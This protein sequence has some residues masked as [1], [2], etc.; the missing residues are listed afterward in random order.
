MIRRNP[1]LA[2]H[3]REQTLRPNSRTAHQIS[4]DLPA[5]IESRHAKTA[6]T[7]SAAC[8]M[9]CRDRQEMVGS[10]VSVFTTNDIA[11]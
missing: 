9:L 8:Q 7:L 3:I 2:T 10:A 4:L 11:F 6:M 1:R 5:L